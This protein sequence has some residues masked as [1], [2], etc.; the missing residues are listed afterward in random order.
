MYTVHTCVAKSLEA[1][2]Q[3]PIM[4]MIIIMIMIMIIV[5]VIVM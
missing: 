1:K 4:I 2:I 3:E 5:I